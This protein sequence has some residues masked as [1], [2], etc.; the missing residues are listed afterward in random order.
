MCRYLKIMCR[1]CIFNISTVFMCRHLKIMF[2]LFIFNISTVFICRHF[3]I[4]CR[5]LFPKHLVYYIHVSTFQ[6]NVSTLPS[7]LST[8][9]DT[10]RASVDPLSVSEFHMS[11][12][13]EYV[14]TL[15]AQN[16]LFLF[17]LVIR[18]LISLVIRTLINRHDSKRD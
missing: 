6:P 11:T 1:L 12:P 7:L 18:T 3:K 9:V 13:Q 4:I 8:C 2:R 5:H 17:S 16:T 15:L 14:S 10:S